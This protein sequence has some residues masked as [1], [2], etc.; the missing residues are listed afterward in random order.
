M[1]WSNGEGD[2]ESA[3]YEYLGQVKDTF[4]GLLKYFLLTQFHI[5]R[6]LEVGWFLWKAYKLWH[7]LRSLAGWLNQLCESGQDYLFVWLM[8]D[9]KTWK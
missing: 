2:S 1:R 6:Q 8:S 4:L 3:E 5:Q 7:Y 9:E